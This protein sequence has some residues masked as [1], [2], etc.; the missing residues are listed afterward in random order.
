MKPSLLAVSV[1]ALS[2]FLPAQALAAPVPGGPRVPSKVVLHGDGVL[3][4]S[5]LDTNSP[6]Y[7]TLHVSPGHFTRVILPTGFADGF[8]QVCTD[9]GISIQPSRPFADGRRGR[10]IF[11]SSAAAGLR[12]AIVVFQNKNG[13]AIVIVCKL[14]GHVGSL[15][16]S[17]T[18][19]DLLAANGGYFPENAGLTIQPAK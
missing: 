7:L 3:D 16:E 6:V 5:K 17:R 15:E 12:R 11:V 14:V 2:S 9:P 8:H 10:D 18:V 13:M 1:F 4:L 19:R